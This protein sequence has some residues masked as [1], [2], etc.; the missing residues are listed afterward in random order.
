MTTFSPHRRD[1]LKL[2]AVGLSAASLLSLQKAMAIPANAKTGSLM[3]VEHVVIFMQENRAFDHYF[4]TFAGV[5]GHG[6]PRPLRLRNGHSV[7]RQPS[8]EHADG[9]VMPYWADSK[10]SSAYVMGGGD[11]GHAE[12]VSIVNGGHFDG[13]GTSRQMHNRMTHYKAADLPYYHALAS[14]FTI[15]DAYHCSTLTQTYPNR[16]HLWTG[17]NG[18]GAVG[19]EPVLSNYGE[20]ETPSADMAEDRPM[21]PYTWTT[22]AERLEKAGVSWKVY[23]EYDNFGDNIL[24]C[25]ASFR[26]CDRSSNLYKRG[27]SWVSEHR[28]GADRKRSDGEQLVEAFRADIAAGTLPQVSWIVT[29]AAL[30]EHPSYTPAEGENVCAR[31]IAALTDHPE[32]F[33]KTVFIINYDEAG[34]LFDHMPPPMPPADETEG[35]SG[36][37]TAGE[38]QDYDRHPVGPIRGRHPLGLGIRIPAIIVSPWTRG[39]YVCSE[40]FDHVSTLKFL[41]RRFGVM[42][43][44]ISPW[45]RAVS[46]DLTSAFD[47]SAPVTA[48]LSLPSTDDYKARLAHAASQ[49]SLRIPDVQSAGG[50]PRQQRPA[51]PLPYR[52]QAN[53]RP[54]DASVLVDFANTGDKAAVLTVHDY[55]PYA[56]GPWRYTLDRGQTHAAGHWNDGLREVYDL[57]VHGPNGFYRHF[58]GRLR[59]DDKPVDDPVTVTIDEAQGQLV[60]RLENRSGV[61]VALSLAF[62]A[63]YARGDSL[64]AQKAIILAGQSAQTLR[65]DVSAA[66]H[67]YDFSLT[68]GARPGWLRR[69]AGHVE[70][71]VASRTDPAIGPMIL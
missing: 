53:I 61:P 51:R 30:S 46:G 62:A 63:D 54:T 56:Q 64:P 35:W 18:A 36:V 47:F 55:A 42:E 66:D 4:G 28:S 10:T 70:T 65:F 13:W 22:Y 32:V 7:W 9:F 1:L 52:I 57:V 60:L 44:N 29:A 16:L 49:P 14:N 43:P 69:Y 21:Q 25:F 17:C 11:Q 34:G 48:T 8:D 15:C 3:D 6:D 33:A 37:S 59:E 71:G 58:A 20:D 67:W 40:V 39:G 19:G 23:Q 24:H 31:L 68:Q 50:Q 41:E 45:R 12:A 27:R 2:G 38:F 26:P 5:R